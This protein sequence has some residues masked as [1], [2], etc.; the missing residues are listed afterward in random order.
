MNPE[1]NENKE[2]N[3]LSILIVAIIVLVLIIAG[4][5][6]YI[7]RQNKQMAD[8]T[9]LAELDKELLED[10]LNQL[11]TQ[12]EGYKFT[13]SN[14]SLLSLLNTEQAKVQ[15]L[16]EELRTVKST[17][18]QRISELKKELE[19]LRKIMRGYV[20]QID[21]LSRVA[22]ELEIAKKQ[23][24]D[25]ANRATTTAQQLEREK[26]ELTKKVDI[27]SQ[28]DA[29]NIQIK[30]LNN[31]GK[32]AKR[33]KQME[34]FQITFTLAKNNTASV[35]EK[36]VYLR[37]MKPNDEVLVKNRGNVFSFEGKEI[38]YSVKRLVEYDGEELPVTMYWDI[39]EYLS[40]GTYRVDIFAD[41]NQIGRRSFTLD[42]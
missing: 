23:A 11:S 10:E 22:Q 16:Q 41:G 26:K 42:K 18:T 32:E 25:R 1:K 13:I 28:L 36:T 17:N 40:P 12:Y 6:Y 8:M 9:V 7:L 29:S 31:K 39:E 30:P 27:A 5:G 33:I 21:S 34:Q 37:I 4:G 20:I 2:I 24:E 35:G 14:D 38:D 3:K 15:R 19:T